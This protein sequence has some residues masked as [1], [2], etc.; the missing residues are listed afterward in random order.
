LRGET[1]A[2]GIIR[3]QRQNFQTAVKQLRDNTR[4][5]EQGA[6]SNVLA[7]SVRNRN[8][9]LAQN[10]AN[11]LTEIYI[12]RNITQ[13]G[14]EAT[15]AMEVIEDQ[16]EV[17][18]TNL[19]EGENALNEYKKER[20][21]F[22]LNEEAS[23][24]IGELSRLEVRRTESDIQ[25]RELIALQRG[26]ISGEEGRYLLAS[27]AGQWPAIENLV[28][29]LS[30]QLVELSILRGKYTEAHLQIQTL[31]RS[32][33][34]TEQ[35]ILSAV[36]NTI[37]S[38]HEQQQSVDAGIKEY[39]GRLQELP[40]TERQLAALTRR[41]QVDADLYTFLLQAHEEAR[42][43]RASVVSN[44]QVIDNAIEPSRPILPNTQL[45]L[46][47]ALLLGLAFGIAG[48]F[49]M[50]QR[51]GT[52]GSVEEVEQQLGLPAVG[53]LPIARKEEE[54]KELTNPIRLAE[55]Q[56]PIA[57]AIRALRT[58]VQSSR[59]EHP[60]WRILLTSPLSGEGKS[61]VVP[62]LAV[63][64]SLTG[65][66]T[67]LIDADLRL[68]ALHN[69]F[70]VSNIGGLTD[71]LMGDAN[72]TEVRINILENLDL[73]TAGTTI[74][75]PAEALTRP[76]LHELLLKGV[77][78]YQFVIIDTPAGAQFT[79]AQIIAPSVDAVYLLVEPWSSNR[80][81]VKKAHSQLSNVGASVR[82]LIANR[83][84]V[85]KDRYTYYSYYSKRRGE[86]DI[87]GTKRSLWRFIRPSK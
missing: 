4:I 82:G 59:G 29:E 15:Q 41:A 80:D 22:L 58:Q 23:L 48:A 67:L 8:P 55:S 32:I 2:Q 1:Y 72:L 39:E 13:L 38:V 49:L 86:G 79:D 45:N 26:L 52:I 64:F 60:I 75:N 77:Y 56:S 34:E 11:S 85:R 6:G 31:K 20:G 27:A 14:Q 87:A 57:E 33:A 16:L 43:R 62:G 17:T 74:S 50:E 18:Q 10:I 84:Q 30:T 70:R 68:P 63:A 46:I 65:K 53:Y 21:I 51:M 47:L 61:T 73:L 19:T 25:L 42:I 76:S 3:I 83:I 35:R 37:T 78:D 44:I 54:L 28:N 69:Y 40:E 66:R 36:E 5:S 81:A 12:D 71:L 7:V 9:A 24:L